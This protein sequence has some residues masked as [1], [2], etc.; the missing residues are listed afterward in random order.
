MSGVTS[1][2][3]VMPAKQSTI[4]QTIV[5]TL[6]APR[7]LG[8][9]IR[10][11]VEFREKRKLY[12]R[13]L[14]EKNL[15]QNSSVPTTSLRNS[16]EDSVLKIFIRMRWIPETDMTSIKEES[17]KECIEHRS[18][19]ESKKYDI[20]FLDK[21]V[22]RLKADTKLSSLHLRVCK[23]AHDYEKLLLEHGYEHLI[24]S[25][26]MVA[27]QHLSSR[28]FHD[29]L[30]TQADGLIRL[31][32]DKYKTDYS[33]FLRDLCNKAESMDTCEGTVCIEN[34]SRRPIDQ[35]EKRIRGTMISKKPFRPVSHTNKP[36]I[37]T[38]RHREHNNDTN[39]RPSKQITPNCLNPKCNGKH[40]L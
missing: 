32:R 29:G 38:K 10:D 9:E 4:R 36:S 11:F 26:P 15:E 12:E 28:L 22:K 39:N 33:I 24:D 40:Y 27:V 21:L 3:E 19:I 30:K 35:H 18:K 6:E 13:R 17:L 31:N 1:T 37:G 25:H 5:E 7:L 16:I 2:N 14:K 20:F 34:H 8:I 23:L